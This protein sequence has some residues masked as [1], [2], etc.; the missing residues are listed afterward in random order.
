MGDAI[1]S[2]KIGVIVDSASFH[3]LMRVI[4]IGQVNLKKLLEVVSREVSQAIQAPV[5]IG[6]AQ[7]ITAAQNPDRFKKRVKLGGFQFISTNPCVKDSDD[8][9]VNRRIVSTN[10]NSVAALVIVTADLLDYVVSLE[11]KRAQHIQIFVAAITANESDGHF[12]LSVHSRQIIKEHQYTLIDLG[13][14]KEDLLL[15]EWVDS[16][17][18]YIVRTDTRNGSESTTEESKIPSDAGHLNL[19]EWQNARC[20]YLYSQIS[21]YAGKQDLEGIQG[22]SKEISFL[23]DLVKTTSAPYEKVPEKGV[24][25]VALKEKNK[26]L[27]LSADVIE[28]REKILS[29]LSKHEITSMAMLFQEIPDVTKQTLRRNL[30]DLEA[31]GLVTFIGKLK[32]SRYMLTQKT[33]NESAASLVS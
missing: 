33:E 11:A 26:E 16:V 17:R 6:S 24:Q 13:N 8:E 31:E 9:E 20:I 12:P 22:A 7:Y 30:R 28:R 19:H 14:Y 15:T 18:P 3:N 27:F 10:P 1:K 2:K 4:G 29:V 5:T 23:I 21:V 25:E 32:G